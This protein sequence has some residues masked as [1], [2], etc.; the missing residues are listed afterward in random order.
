MKH[1]YGR[2]HM[3]HLFGLDLKTIFY[4]LLAV[5]IVFGIFK[6]MFK[7]VIFLA[8]AGVLFYFFRFL[9]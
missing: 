9:A 6:K 3:K 1:R 7:L 4:L 8:L 2:I 5:I